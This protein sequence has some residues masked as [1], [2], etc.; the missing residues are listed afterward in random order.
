MRIDI[1]THTY[2][3]DFADYL[4]TRNQFPNVAGITTTIRVRRGIEMD[5]GCGQL[6]KRIVLQPPAL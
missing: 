1:H 5:A 2:F 6:R 3:Q 4:A